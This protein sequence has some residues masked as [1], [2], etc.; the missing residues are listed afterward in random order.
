[1]CGIVGVVGKD[2]NA[3]EIFNGLEKLQYRG[4][5]SA[6]I[7]VEK[8]KKF[9]LYKE[10][11]IIE[12]LRQ[13]CSNNLRGTVA[14]G[15]T[16]WATHGRV[17]KTN[18]HPI[19]SANG[20]WAVVHNGIIENYAEL[21]KKFSDSEKFQTET[22]TEIVVKML[23]K[24]E[25][26][27]D[28]ENFILAT[29]QLKGSFALC[30]MKKGR[31]SLFLAKNKSPLY[32]Q[33]RENETIVAS[34]PVCFESGKYFRME[35][36]EYAE[37][38]INGVKFY[39]DK[40]KIVVKKPFGDFKSESSTSKNGFEHFMLK[41]IYE[42][43]KV[44]KNLCECYQKLN[45]DYLKKWWISKVKL[46]GCGSAYHSCLVGA[47]YFKKH[48]NI[49]AEAVTAS[50]FLYNKE[51]LDCSTLC[52]FVSQSGETADTISALKKAF[53][54]TK[55]IISLTNVQYSTL[56]TLSPNTL[57][58]CAGTEIAVASTKAYTCQIIALY[59][60]VMQIKSEL[61]KG[62]KQVLK[63]SNKLKK[64]FV[65]VSKL[66]DNIKDQT[67]VFFIGR[68]LDYITALE[69]AL[70]LKEISYI[71][72]NAFPAGELKHGVLALIQKGTPVIVL[73][74]NKSLIQ[75]TLNNAFE[76][77]SRGAKIFLF[78]SQVPK[79]I[80]EEK[81]YECFLLPKSNN[82]LTSIFETV[83][84]QLLAYHVSVM[85]GLD[86]DKPRNLAKSVTVE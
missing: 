29:K 5:D 68:N 74:S 51:I 46:I 7:C 58:I 59:L 9:Y 49:D 10:T 1:M 66:A 39:D 28:F 2:V 11:G 76:A 54:K 48:L 50:E 47:Q 82:D 18:A 38:T 4:Y 8:N 36:G 41:E 20:C 72:C 43:P 15:H 42:T 79:A 16:R 78:A 52:I 45:W 69:G 71:N 13:I 75:K 12:N 30:V 26:E 19:L 77:K 60:L 86:P 84:L 27:N 61:N 25:S 64:I 44:I 70:K 3:T 24:S 81:S 6:G 14:I 32:V 57:P 80:G 23:E 67:D 40:G 62:I 83:A 22:D 53:K 21:K 85:K 33:I 56:A 17:S 65:D 37:A 63:V 55:K 31:S 34:D 73:A 35:D